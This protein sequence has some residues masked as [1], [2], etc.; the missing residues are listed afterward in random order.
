MKA[1]TIRQPWAWLIVHAGK[2]VE[3]RSWRS[4]YR[5][6]FL[7]HAAKG[8][9]RREYEEA[10]EWS[11]A[12]GAIEIPAFGRLERG[13][14]IGSVE[15]VDV[16]DHSDSPWFMGPKAFVLQAPLPLPFMPVKGRLGFFEVP[17]NHELD[18]PGP[19][20]LCSASASG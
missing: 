10:K 7:V 4:H 11:S 17:I 1:L 12:C 3:N 18:S 14:V 16:L 5:G 8:M 15:L 19:L 2:N 13:G 20:G 6:R 9:T